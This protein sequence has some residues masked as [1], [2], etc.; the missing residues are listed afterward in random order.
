MLQKEKSMPWN[1]IIYLIASFCPRQFED[2]CTIACCTNKGIHFDSDL[3][4][5]MEVGNADYSDL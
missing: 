3:P 4:Q 1:F 2:N 5:L